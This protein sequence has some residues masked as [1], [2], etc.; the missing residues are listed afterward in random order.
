MKPTGGIGYD[1]QF[2][3][4]DACF[5]CLQL[6]SFVKF[7]VE[8]D[9]QSILWCVAMLQPALGSSIMV[10]DSDRHIVIQSTTIDIHSLYHQFKQSCE[11]SHEEHCSLLQAFEICTLVK[12]AALCWLVW[13]TVRAEGGKLMKYSF[14]CRMFTTETGNK[15]R[16]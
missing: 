7:Y 14:Y 6:L 10:P 2:H 11:Q 1:C 8:S 15:C 13:I 12:L 16:C 9:H 5:I 4:S 3:M